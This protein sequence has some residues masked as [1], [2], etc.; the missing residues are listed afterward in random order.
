MHTI[1]CKI[2]PQSKLLV[3]H[4]G[5]NHSSPIISVICTEC[6]EE[7]GNDALHLPFIYLISNIAVF[8]DTK[9]TTI[10]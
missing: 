5:T 1:T 9:F 8:N 10:S 2:H 7:K 4:L 3:L 6:R